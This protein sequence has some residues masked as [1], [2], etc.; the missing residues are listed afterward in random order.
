MSSVYGLKSASKPSLISLI[1]K[2][3][4]YESSSSLTGQPFA[5]LSSDAIQSD[6]IVYSTEQQLHLDTV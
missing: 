1:A 4:E 2:T 5:I 6:L 3:P